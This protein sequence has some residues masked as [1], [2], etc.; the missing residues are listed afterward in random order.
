MK[1]PLIAM[2][3]LLAVASVQG[4]PT[5]QIIG[6]EQDHSL[7][8]ASDCEHFYRTTFTSFAAQVHERDQR[9]IA[10][11]RGQELR[12]IARHEGGISVRGWNRPHARLIA[13]SYAAALT[14]PQAASVLDSIRVTDAGGEVLVDGPAIDQ[15]SAWWVNLTLYVPRQAAVDVHA[16]NGGIAIRNMGGQVNA[17]ATTGG[18]SLANSTG[19]YKITTDS[20]G[21]T[22]DHVDGTVE[23]TSQ[24]G[25]IAVKLPAEN[26][27][28]VEAKT[29]EGG[30]ILC[31]LKSCDDGRANWS[32][33]GSMLRI[34]TGI[35]GIRVTTGAPI[36]I[37]PIGVN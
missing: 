26:Y 5:R 19:R 9:D 18:I 12:V 32:A 3:T 27:P 17:R 25:T 6:A 34:G 36:I 31:N 24:Q 16:A 8:G 33:G 2:F 29:A 7:A 15:K 35:P 30:H 4:A 11:P 21:I 28:S 20:G 22:L 10:A 13:C 14:K 23:A 37:G 1:V